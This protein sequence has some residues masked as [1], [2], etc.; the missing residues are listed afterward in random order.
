[1]PIGFWND[2]NK[3]KYLNSYFEN[4]SKVWVHGDYCMV[5]EAGGVRM[6][7]RSDTT[8]NPN[9]IRIGTAEIYAVVE[10]M[11]EIKDS[12]CCSLKTEKGEKIYLWVVLSDNEK[13]L[14][15][16]LKKEIRQQLTLQC[17]QAHAPYRIN[18]VSEVPYTRSGKKVEKIIK[19]KLSTDSLNNV[20]SLANPNCLVE[21]VL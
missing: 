4:G 15:N 12:I 7:G 2:A 1:M 11:P 17:S 19:Q 13:T 20:E 21:F 3:E 5:S 16:D 10:K 6:L 9:G 18:A 14:D 8:L